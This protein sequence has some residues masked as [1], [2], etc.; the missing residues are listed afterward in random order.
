MLFIDFIFRN[1]IFVLEG[2]FI[3]LGYFVEKDYIFY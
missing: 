2:I 1:M 3:Y